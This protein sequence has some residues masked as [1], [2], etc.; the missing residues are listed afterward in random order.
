[1]LLR[2]GLQQAGDGA[3]FRDGICQGHVAGRRGA[4]VK[5]GQEAKLRC[6]STEGMLR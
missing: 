5:M 1:M 3:G 2:A 4:R 6:G